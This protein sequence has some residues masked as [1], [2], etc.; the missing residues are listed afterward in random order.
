[1]YYTLNAIILKRQ[2][3][4]DDDLLVTVYSFE[5]GKIILQ[6]KGAKRI[7]SK[8]AGHLEPLI[9][10]NLNITHGKYIDQLIGAQIIKSYQQIKSDIILIGYA[11]YFIELIYNLTQEGH[12]D[13]QVFSLLKKSLDFLITADANSCKIARISFGFKLLH[14]LGFDSSVNTQLA[15]N[16]EISYI[17]KNSINSISQ[18]K[19]IIKKL[20]QI[21]KILDQEL[22]QQL[23]QEIKTK[24]FL[25]QVIKS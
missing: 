19:N 16:S 4:K 17:V 22:E 21:N 15:L 2:N 12:A 18:H 6:A 1:M 24:E 20:S 14:L 25:K 3:F 5:R 8:L 23:E 13:K 9:L 10:S 7:K 11:N